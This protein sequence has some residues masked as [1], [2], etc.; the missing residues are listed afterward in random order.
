MIYLLLTI[1]QSTAIFVVF[2]LFNRF[3]IDN[4]QAISINYVV[5]SLFGLVIYKGELSIEILL[6][7]DWF[8][9]GLILGIT[10]IATFFIFALSA[11]KV[12]V[13]LTSVASKMSVVIPVIAGLILLNETIGWLAGSGVLIALLAFYLTLGGGRQR[14]LP[15]KYVILPVLLFL[16]N[17]VNDTIMK[18]TEHHYVT[19]INDRI[20]FLTIV[21]MTS[22]FFGLIIT[23]KRYYNKRVNITLHTIVGG[24]ILGLIN[25]GSTYYILKAMDIFASSVVFPITNAGIVTLSTLIGWS[26]FREKLSLRNW[27]GIALAIAAIIMIANA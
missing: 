14:S 5:A 8:E 15:S 11:Q 27:I 12:G 23:A 22:L 20:L 3:R 4:W 24:S 7:K 21:F 1:L 2:K 19:D 9:F 10:F 25:F 18:Y 16:G 6:G 17:G 13:A 26:V